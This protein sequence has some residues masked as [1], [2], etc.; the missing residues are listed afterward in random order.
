[1]INE[2]LRRKANAAQSE[3]KLQAFNQFV[4]GHK[5]RSRASR[6]KQFW[7]TEAQR[8]C[9]EMRDVEQAVSAEVQHIIHTGKV[10]H[11]KVAEDEETVWKDERRVARDQLLSS[12]FGFK[13]KVQNGKYAPGVLQHDLDAIKGFLSAEM[14]SLQ[15]A[16]LDLET[17]LAEIRLK[18]EAPKPEEEELSVIF[19]K[20]VQAVNEE[21][22]AE[23]CLVDQALHT[24]LIEG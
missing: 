5:K 15:E 21:L 7:F 1:M 18:V 9:K 16:E 23:G 17:E 22:A 10:Y 6:H 14:K 19:A 4:K 13:L 11:L 8:L 12:V 20:Q 3:A 2:L 24:L